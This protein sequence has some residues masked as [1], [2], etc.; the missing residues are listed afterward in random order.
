MTKP[1]TSGTTPDISTEG[2]RRRRREASHDIVRRTEFAT[3]TACGKAIA[4]E[5]S[6]PVAVDKNHTPISTEYYECPACRAI[7][8]LE[9][10]MRG[11]WP[12]FIV[13]ADTAMGISHFLKG[14]DN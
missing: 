7:R 11:A 14:R 12:K 2:K 3:H 5:Y 10:D 1:T 4:L 13:D 8:N 9:N 6:T